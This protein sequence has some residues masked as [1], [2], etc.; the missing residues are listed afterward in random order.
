MCEQKAKLSE[1][2]VAARATFARDV[3][4]LRRHIGTSTIAEYK[5]LQLSSDEAR[6]KCERARLALERHVVMHKC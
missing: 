4:R 6:M 1:E 3:R 5:R 2:C